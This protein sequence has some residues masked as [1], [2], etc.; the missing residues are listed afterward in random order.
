[1]IGGNFTRRRMLAGAAGLVALSRASAARADALD[2]F[3]LTGD[4]PPVPDIE[5]TNQGDD[6]LK[7]SDYRGK[8]LL[9]NAWATWC[10]PCIK[11]MPS[12][13]TVQKRLGGDEFQ[14]LP[15]SMDREGWVKI[16]LFYREN[17]LR[18]LPILL[19]YKAQIARV[20]KPRGLPFTLLIDRDG[21]E[22][23]R[24]LGEVFWDAPEGISLLKTFIEA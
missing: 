15:I 14:V 6:I 24:A 17:N 21:T 8:V 1:M 3:N 5:F 20:L 11:E 10:G 16:D 23:G 18:N 19:E 22:L 2:N 13:D 9:L 12:L 4:K 7:L